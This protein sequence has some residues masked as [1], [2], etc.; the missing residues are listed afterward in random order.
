MGA[1]EKVG[2]VRVLA[3]YLPE[4]REGYKSKQKRW[5]RCGCSHTPLAR[6][7]GYKLRVLDE[8]CVKGHQELNLKPRSKDRSFCNAPKSRQANFHTYSFVVPVP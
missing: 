7:R 8:W 5:A 2:E 1:S 3:C 4:G 6:W